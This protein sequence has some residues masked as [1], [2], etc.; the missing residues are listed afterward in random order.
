MTQ[1]AD[2]E[3]FFRLKGPVRDVE[4][5][6]PLREGVNPVGSD[7]SNHLILDQD[8]VSRAHAL[9]VVEPGRLLVVDLDSKNGTFVNSRRVRQAEISTGDTVG[10]G[11]VELRLEELHPED[12]RLAV[13]LPAAAADRQRGPQDPDTTLTARRERD[14]RLQRWLGLVGGFLERLRGAPGGDAGSALSLLTEA[15]GAEGA[16]VLDLSGTNPAILSSCGEIDPSALDQIAGAWHRQ[17]RRP[18]PRHVFA[19]RQA[20]TGVLS[21]NSESP[22]CLLVCGDFADRKRSEPLLATLLDLYLHLRPATPPTARQAPAASLP[23]VRFPPAYVPGVSAAM[24]AVYARM[25]P[26]LHSDVPVLIVGE[27]G[28]G[29]ELLARSLHLSSLRRSG[30]MV[31]VN[32]AAIPAELLESE[33]FGIGDRVATGVAGRRGVFEQAAGGTLFLDEI[34]EMPVELHVKLLRVLEDRELRPL[35]E[36]PRPIDVRVLAATNADLGAQ[37]EAGRFRRDLYFRI[38][39]Y[40]LEIPPL[41][42]RREDVPVLVE[43]FLRRF[44]AEVGKPVRGVT[45]RALRALVAR[46]WPGNVRELEHEVRRLVYLCAPNQA[47]EASML[48]SPAEKTPVPSPAA[49]AT[50]PSAASGELD[51]DLKSIE[52]R[53]IREAL[54][55]A[56]GNQ[57][58]AAKLL[59]VSRHV[60]RRK[61]DRYELH[62]WFA[63]PKS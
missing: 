63:E 6:L 24:A 58:R 12:A 33:L 20:A 53:V 55:R 18:E 7:P 31:A 8:G 48:E 45:V 23:E 34:A 11:P 17:P 51:L 37:V 35:G 49:T 15:L 44:C 52:Q 42:R 5:S 26:V 29:K 57:V 47:I 59:G 13:E 2:I 38:A 22:R 30:P 9:L 36:R 61:I 43:G 60:L 39:G 14:D 54:R 19:T 46:D 4:L 28:V 10:F 1:A 32:C 21:R 25:R 50:A 16:C 3:R 40:V 62:D 56:R 41:R 27:T